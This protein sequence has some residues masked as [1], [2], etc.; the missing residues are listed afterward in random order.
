VIKLGTI[1]AEG[2]ASLYCYTCNNDVKDE[3]LREHLIIAGIDV[4]AQ[5]KT[6]KTVQ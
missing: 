5:T 4:R 1:T 3:L 6:E 2:D